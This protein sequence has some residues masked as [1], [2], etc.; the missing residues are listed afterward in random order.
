MVVMVPA[1]VESPLPD[2]HCARDPLPRKRILILVHPGNH[3]TILQ[4][5]MMALRISFKDWKVIL[6]PDS[7]LPAP[8]SA[9]QHIGHRF[10]RNR[11]GKRPVW[12]IPLAVVSLINNLKA[13]VPLLG[14]SRSIS[15]LESL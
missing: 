15:R 2:L 6:S 8:V 4:L 7:R 13:G 14:R 3:A 11:R 9:L 12:P 10:Q 5:Q 1:P